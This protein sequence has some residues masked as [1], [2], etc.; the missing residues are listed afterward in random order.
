MLKQELALTLEIETAVKLLRTGLAE[1]QSIDGA[2]DFYH[3]PFLLLSSGFE[4]LM[5]CMICLKRRHDTGAFPPTDEL[6]THDLMELKNR[7]LSK[8]I[9]QTTASSRK[10]TDEDYHFMTADADFQKL[11]RMLSLFGEFARYYNLDVVTGSTKPPVNAEEMWEE[12]E[13]DLVDES[14]VLSSLYHDVNRID[15]FYGE[16][17]CIIVGKL[18]RFARALARQFTLGDLGP[19]AKSHTGTIDCFLFL[20]DDDLGRQD[21]TA[22]RGT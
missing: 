22:R 11:L 17:N 6:K 12:Y 18:E 15:D 3:L 8:C 2:N 19:E 16:L 13:R 7:V 10:A 20:T 4:R 1:L 14:G 5:K 9:S 21:Y